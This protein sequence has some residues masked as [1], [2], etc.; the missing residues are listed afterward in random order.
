M[1][2]KDIRKYA[3]L[4]QDMGLTGLEIDEGGAHVRLERSACSAPAAQ[5]SV[6]LAAVPETPAQE[7]QEALTLVRSPMVGVFYAAANESAAPYVAIGDKV[8]PGDVLCIIEAMKL[9]NEI[10]CECSGTV[11]EI[12]VGNAQTVDY[13]HVLFRIRKEQA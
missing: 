4:M 8:Q 7:E 5:A 6:T 2:E 12:C 3:K 1:Q 10:T 9:M 11:E 13:G